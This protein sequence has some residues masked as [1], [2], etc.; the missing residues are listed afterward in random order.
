MTGPAQR[1]PQ[2]RTDPAGSDDAH[3][4]AGGAVRR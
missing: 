4:E 1:G 3:L 2:D